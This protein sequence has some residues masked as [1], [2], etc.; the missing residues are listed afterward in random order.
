MRP[1]NFTQNARSRM[2]ISWQTYEGLQISVYSLIEAAKFLLTEGFEFVLSERF[3]QDVLEEYFGRQHSLGRWNDNPTLKEFGYNDNTLRF[4]RSCA[5]VMGNTR[6]EIY[7]K[8]R[9]LGTLLT[10]LNLKK[11]NEIV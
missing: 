6:G 5:T 2:F 7:L 8:E 9:N 11:E 10:T 4:Q 3:C 1:G